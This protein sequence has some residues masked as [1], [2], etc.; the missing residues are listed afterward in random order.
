MRYFL[1]WESMVIDWCTSLFLPTK[2]FMLHFHLANLTIACMRCFCV[3]G[4]FTNSTL[5]SSKVWESRDYHMHII[6]SRSFQFAR[7]KIQSKSIHTAYGISFT[8]K[9]KWHFMSAL[10][11]IIALRW[12]EPNEITIEST[13]RPAWRNYETNSII[14]LRRSQHVFI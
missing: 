9:K 12:S 10:I 14:C 1:H 6:M 13:L 11:F 3:A 2:T 5:K 7:K 8:A 4:N